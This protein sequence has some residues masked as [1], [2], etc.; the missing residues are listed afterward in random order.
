MRLGEPLRRLGPGAAMIVLA[1]MALLLS[2]TGRRPSPEGPPRVAVFQFNSQ[3]ILNEGLRGMYD[4][5][6][7]RGWEDGKTMLVERFN[8]ENDMPTAASIARELVSGRFG[9]VFTV[10]TN[11]LQAVAKANREG[12]VK[13]VF[14]VV[15]NPRE[16]GIGIN[17]NDPSDHPKNMVGIGSLMPVGE[18][19]AMARRINPQLRRVG[20]PWNPSQANSE[21]YTRMAREAAG[22]MGIELL[23]GNVDN[24]SMVGEVTSS[25]AGRGAEAIMLTGDLTVSLAMDTLLATAAQ[26][27]IPVFSTLPVAVGRGALFAIG[28]DYYRIG[29]QLGELAARVLSGEDPN[30]MPIVYELPKKFVVDPRAGAR[31]GARWSFPPDALAEATV[32]SD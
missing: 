8:S 11:C 26:S 21:T 7:D 9:Y 1:G 29:R 18:L 12:R 5:L 13:H 17:P 14:G 20:L 3:E 2:D 30:R 4:A 23:E 31:L 19:L 16:A 25:L 27:R 10:S 32:K 6:R 15:A 28:A 22:P 24:T